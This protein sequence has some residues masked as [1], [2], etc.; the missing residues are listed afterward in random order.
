MRILGSIVLPSPAIMQVVDAEIE[1]RCAV[2]PKII[3]DQSIRN[4][5]VFPQKF[6]HQFQRGVLVALGLDQHIQNLAL[7]VDGAPQV[8]HAP[9]DFQID[10]VEMPSRMRFQAALSQVG[11]NHRSEMVHPTP[12]RLVRHRHSAFGQQILDVAQAEG[13]PEVEPYCLVNDFG[14]ETIPGVA[15][16]LHSLRYW[17]TSRTASP[18]RRDNASRRNQALRSY[19][20]ELSSYAHQL[21]ANRPASHTSERERDA[22]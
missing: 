3:R 17:A 9:I 20:L 22:R 1:G 13:E 19:E 4:D 2:G 7:G 5:G 15:D 18:A 12:N 21:T 16:F 8:N 11:R 14:R 6:A 10:L